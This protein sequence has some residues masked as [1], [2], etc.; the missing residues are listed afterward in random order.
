MLESSFDFEWNK[1]VLCIVSDPT[2]KGWESWAFM[3]V[4]SSNFNLNN[5]K[6]THSYPKVTY[7]DPMVTHSD[8]TYLPLHP[9]ASPDQNLAIS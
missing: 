1:V 8:P 4:F 3:K 9:P 5:N 6:V 2:N 7:S